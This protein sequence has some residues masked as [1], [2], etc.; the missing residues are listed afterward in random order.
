M[1]DGNMQSLWKFASWVATYDF[2]PWA[3]IW[4][5][6]VKKPIATL[7]VAFVAAVVCAVFVNPVALIS[8]VAI[9]GVISLGYGWP[10][11]SIHGL[12]AR[13][14]FHDRRV[15]AGDSAR[16]TVSVRNTW[17]WPVWGICLTGDFGSESTISLARVA[18]WSVTDF[19][20]EF[21]PYCRGEYPHAPVRLATAFP[22]GLQKASRGVEVERSLI[23]WPKILPLDTLLD[24]AETRPMNDT[25]SEQRIGDSGDMAGTRPFRNGDSLR[26]VHWA[27]TARTGAMIVCER[28]SPVLASVRVVFDSDPAIHEGTGATSTLEWSSRIAASI[29]AAY[30]RHNARVECCFGHETILVAAGTEGLRRF[31]DQLSRFQPRKHEHDAHECRRI[32]HHNCGVFQITIT[33]DCGTVNR[34]EHRH[35]HGDQLWIVLDSQQT[36]HDPLKAPVA[37]PGRFMKL[38]WKSGLE[39]AFRQNWR[40]ICRAG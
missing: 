31:L 28:E 11:I 2:C 9:L 32:H 33:T 1:R 10:A 27:Q 23:V 29:C 7:S 13:L 39:E 18:G 34:T 6:W 25:F 30:Q 37:L 16:A 19:S 22:F 4:L 15:T 14:R 5:Y 8:A 3:N 24:A 17:P 40:T 35:V 26:R 20:W 38:G 21:V 36:V 12:T